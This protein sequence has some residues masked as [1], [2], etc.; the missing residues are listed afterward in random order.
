MGTAAE[1]VRK[2]LI[3]VKRE[4]G[5]VKRKAAFLFLVAIEVKKS[6]NYYLNNNILR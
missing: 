4:T 1:A 5:S 3:I 6:Y 2:E